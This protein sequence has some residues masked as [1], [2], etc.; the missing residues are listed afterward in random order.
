MELIGTE[1][2]PGRSCWG[3][4]PQQTLGQDARATAGKMPALPATV[5]PYF[6]N[7]SRFFALLSMTW[8]KPFF[9]K[10]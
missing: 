10:P 5:S 4:P 6:A 9:S 8:P 2:G 3:V 1:I 7:L